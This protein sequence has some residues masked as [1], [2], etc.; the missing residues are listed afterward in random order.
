MKLTKKERR[1]Y[2]YMCRFFDR[3]GFPPTTREMAEALGYSTTS[4]VAYIKRKLVDRGLL[5]VSRYTAR[6]M[7]ITRK[8]TPRG[9]TIRERELN[10]Y[11]ANAE[12]VSVIFADMNDAGEFSAVTVITRSE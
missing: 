7:R 1:M 6:G 11:C 2:D 8:D 4:S 5:S 3:N 12:D 10:A 9:M